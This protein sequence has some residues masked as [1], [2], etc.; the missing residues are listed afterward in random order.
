MQ[1][2][3][4]CVPNFS[5]GRE[6]RIVDEIVAEPIVRG[7]A[8]PNSNRAM[9]HFRSIMDVTIADFVGSRLLGCLVPKSGLADFQP[10]RAQLGELTVGDAIT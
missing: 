10:T 3:V 1:T 6:R 7:L 4:E 9:E 8:N 5:E 2:I